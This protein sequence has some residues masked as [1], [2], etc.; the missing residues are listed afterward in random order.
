MISTIIASSLVLLGSFFVLLASIGVLKMPDFYSR[1]HT[2]TKAGAFGSA[3]VLLGYLFIEPSLRVII[4]SVL[5]IGFFYLTAPVAAHAM[6]RIAMG[7]KMPMWKR[8][9]SDQK[10]TKPSPSDTK[11]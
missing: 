4:Q 3:L 6:A 5:I 2:A 10:T 1:L 8:S 7:D 9:E 11:D